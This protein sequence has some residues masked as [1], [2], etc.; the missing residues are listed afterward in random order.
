MQC[1]LLSWPFEGVLRLTGEIIV[2][3]VFVNTCPIFCHSLKSLD[4]LKFHFLTK[5]RLELLQNF[6]LNIE[7][8]P[9]VLC[10]FYLFYLP[11]SLLLQYHF[12]K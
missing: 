1:K 5:K 7:M 11:Q 8:C 3:R 12:Y 4:K 6:N 10:T 2:I 9:G